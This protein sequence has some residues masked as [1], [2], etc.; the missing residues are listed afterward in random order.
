MQQEKV[1]GRCY[2][3]EVLFF[4]SVSYNWATLFLQQNLIS[5]PKNR[6]KT[7]NIL[8]ETSP[9]PY[10]TSSMCRNWILPLCDS[11]VN[12]QTQ[13]KTLYITQTNTYLSLLEISREGKC[14][15]LGGMYGGL[16]VQM[17]P[18]MVTDD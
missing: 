11:S 17:G 1:A 12:N 2:R 3:W 5:S 14:C 15:Y 16:E 7:K 13:Q 18:G 6:S 4:S 8:S 10:G 9:M